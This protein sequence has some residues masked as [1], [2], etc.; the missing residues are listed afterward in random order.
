MDELARTLDS[1]GLT[2][3]GV[4]AL[5]AD[6]VAGTLVVVAL[7]GRK[8]T[9]PLPAGGPAAPKRVKAIKRVAGGE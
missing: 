8:F 1:L 6:R 9:A 7:D 2:W 5:T 4:W 3:G